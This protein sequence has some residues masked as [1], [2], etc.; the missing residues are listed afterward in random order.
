MENQKMFKIIGTTLLGEKEIPKLTLLLFLLLLLL[1]LLL[2]TV[3]W[4]MLYC[5]FFVDTVCRC[6][7]NVVGASESQ[8]VW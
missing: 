7:G 3:V 2:L 6:I 8:V 5:T 1:L 4:E